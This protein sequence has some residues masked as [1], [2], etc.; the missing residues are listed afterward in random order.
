MISMEIKSL[1]QLLDGAV[2]EQF[3]DVWGQV[4]YNANDSNTDAVANRGFTMT[5]MLKP[6]EDR[7]GAILSVDFKTKLVGP[8]KH[9]A[10]I[11]MRANDNGIVTAFQ[12]TKEIPGQQSLD[13]A[14][15]PLPEVLQFQI[16]AP[17]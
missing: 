8:V 15:T 11:T 4:L 6:T 9:G 5:V 3:L 12:Q 16:K 14:E 17:K 10:L 2:T 1:D 13:G 7:Q